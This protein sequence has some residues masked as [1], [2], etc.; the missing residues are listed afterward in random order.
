MNELFVNVRNN[1]GSVIISAAGGQE[2]A[3]EAIKVDGKPLK[4]A[5]LLTVSWNA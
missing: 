5:R 4:S 2:S 3:L 1:T